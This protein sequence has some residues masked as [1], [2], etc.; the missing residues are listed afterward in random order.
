MLQATALVSEV[1]E[2]S[3]KQLYYFSSNYNLPDGEH[4][5]YSEPKV[6][7]KQIGSI[8]V[9][10]RS[11]PTGVRRLF[12]WLLLSRAAGTSA[13]RTCQHRGLAAAD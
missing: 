13:G 1:H 11:C 3:D 7:A 4:P 8:K 12:T 6:T 2:F 5:V 9:I 10:E